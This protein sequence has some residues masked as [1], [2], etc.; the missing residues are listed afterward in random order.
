MS[1]YIGPLLRPPQAYDWEA[2]FPNGKGQKRKATIRIVAPTFG[3][4]KTLSSGIPGEP[5]IHFR[6]LLAGENLV[7]DIRN[8]RVYMARNGRSDWIAVQLTFRRTDRPLAGEIASP[9]RTPK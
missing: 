8:A 3:D 7:V 2:V 4:D 9:Y 1:A 5:T 6:D